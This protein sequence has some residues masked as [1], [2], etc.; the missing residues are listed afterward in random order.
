YEET[1]VNLDYDLNFENSYFLLFKKRAYDAFVRWTA[2]YPFLKRLIGNSAS[3]IIAGKSSNPQKAHCFNERIREIRKQCPRCLLVLWIDSEISEFDLK[4]TYACYDA[5]AFSFEAN[6]PEYVYSLPTTTEMYKSIFVTLISKSRFYLNKTGKPSLVLL[7]ITDGY[8]WNREEDTFGFLKYLYQ[9]QPELISAGVF[10][11]IYLPYTGQKEKALQIDNL[12]EKDEKFCAFQ[13]ATNMFLN[14]FQQKT[15]QLKVAAEQNFTSHNGSFLDVPECVKC[16]ELEIT[17]NSCNKTCLNYVLSNGIMSNVQCKEIPNY[18]LDKQKCPLTIIDSSAYPCLPCSKLFEFGKKIECN[19]TYLDGVRKNLIIQNENDLSLYPDVIA[20]LPHG[21][22]CC[23]NS[24]IF[25][26]CKGTAFNSSL[27]CSSYPCPNECSK[28]PLNACNS[29][30]IIFADGKSVQCEV[31]NNMCEASFPCTVLENST[32]CPLEKFSYLKL[33]IQGLAPTP[34][35][36]PSTGDP[37]IDCGLVSSNT[38]F[39][40]VEIPQK[41]YRIECVIK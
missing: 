32:S 28:V 36:F 29:T 30:Y 9:N 2:Y 21:Q 26:C 39:C 22:K 15:V 27:T 11:I 38:T 31:K 34:I 20:A 7:T 16:T 13:R 10:G 19:I 33:S 23:L 14:T 5:F 4:N 3:I 8:L 35:L 1:F 40:G 12:R 41:N 25:N 6:N 18:P 37:N 24:T 17:S